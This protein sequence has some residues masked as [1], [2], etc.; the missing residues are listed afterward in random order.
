MTRARGR[1]WRTAEFLGIVSDEPGPRPGSRR[2][3]LGLLLVGGLVVVSLAVTSFW[4]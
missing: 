3:W 2:W 4:G 1:V